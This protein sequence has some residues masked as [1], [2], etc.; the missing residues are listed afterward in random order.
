M[1]R[2]V[3]VCAVFG[4]AAGAAL[5]V[6][7]AQ[8]FVPVNDLSVRDFS[9]DDAA[10]SGAVDSSAYPDLAMAPDLAMPDLAMPDLAMPD[11]VMP[12]LTTPPDLTAPPDLTVL[13]DLTTPP[14]LTPITCDLGSS[15]DAGTISTLYLAGVGPSNALVSTRYTEGGGWDS[16]TVDGTHPV[17]E[18]TIAIG[19][20]GQPLIAAKQTDSKSTLSW[21]SFDPCSGTWAPLSPLFTDASTSLRPALVGGAVPDVVFRGF[22]LGDNHLYHAAL[23]SGTWVKDP[24]LTL[25]TDLA[26][27]AVRVGSSLHAIHTGTNHHVFDATVGGAVVD[28]NGTSVKVPAAV[29][30]S[31]GTIWVVFIGMDTNLYFATRAAGAST[32]AAPTAACAPGTCLATSDQA[33]SLALTAAGAPIIAF[34]GTNNHVYTTQWNGTKFTA[35]IDA[36]ASGETS[37]NGPV[38]ATGIGSADAE[39]VYVRTIDGYAR[40]ARLTGGAWSGYTTVGTQ[41]IASTPALASKP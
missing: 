23:S 32:Y 37:S 34:H 36:V 30:T 17:A 22:F 14:D 16:Y 8:D 1:K 41:A 40:H 18:A 7:C 35:P 2:V 38:V 20:G 15:A 12:D 11:L 3:A 39:L 4:L 25:L 5:C 29:V 19:P 31:D 24:Q 10:G 33:P 21:T 13:P 6:G 26:P 27:Q 28:T 9:P